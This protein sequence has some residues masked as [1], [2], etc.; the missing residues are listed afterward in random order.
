[1]TFVGMI[2]RNI[3][4]RPLRAALTASAVAIG[5][6]AVV[7]LGILTTSLK[8]TATQ[9]LQV[10]SADFTITQRNTDDIINSTI[11]EDDIA[12][13]GEIPGVRR[14]VGA[15]IA[16]DDYDADHPLVI[17]VG[18]APDDQE[19]FGVEII[20]GTSY[21]ADAADEVMLGYTFANAVQKGVGDTVAFDD[22]VYRVTGI[23]RTNVSF[24]NSTVMMPLAHLQGANRLAGQ[25]T[26]GFVKV[27]PGARIPK[28]RAAIEDAFAQLATIETA[29]EFGRADRNLT[30]ISAANTGGSILAG[31][32]AVTGVLNT[33]LLSF[34]ERIREFGIYRS[35]GW[36]RRRV[37]ALVI[38]EAV[39]VSLAG[40]TLGMLLGWV[41]VNV[42]QN[43]EQLRG[44]F[45][46]IYEANVFTRSLLFG[47]VVAFLGA[48]YP[49]L[50]AALVAPITAVRRE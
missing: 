25:V 20:E 6:M 29:S 11:S 8:A 44:I 16:T 48:L 23:Y 13:I 3:R 42:L 47:I 40:A 22:D 37:I 12:A 33:S 14:A 18:L 43:L 2:L 38:G 27:E 7:A 41:A 9:L 39:V 30:L 5:V 34:F 15:L 4:A 10:G 19:P 46:P 32:I 21:T 24:G 31:L 26:L 50:R 45:D 1:M 17:Q 36:S 49:A 35:I 28:V